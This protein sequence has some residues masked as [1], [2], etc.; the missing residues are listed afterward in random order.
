[1]NLLHSVRKGRLRVD[2]WSG[3]VAVFV[4]ALAILIA[5]SLVAL[6]GYREGRIS[7][8]SPYWPRTYST[9]DKNWDHSH[10]LESHGTVYAPSVVALS[11]RW[12]WL[13][14]Y[15]DWSVWSAGDLT[16]GGAQCVL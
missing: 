8:S 13:P 11:K 5:I 9:T 6:G 1:M 2:R 7:C 4:I 16:S 15:G 12:N 10:W 3:R 14:R